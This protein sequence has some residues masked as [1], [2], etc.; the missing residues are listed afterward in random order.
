MLL[1]V[2]SEEDG[3]LGAF[4]A[5]EDDADFGACLIPEPTG[6][7]L[8]CAQAGAVTFKGVVRGK[9]AHAALRL[10][11]KSA[12]DRYVLVHAALAELE[13]R[14]NADVDHPLMT[15]HELPYPVLVGK[16][17]GGRWSSQ[18]PDELV[19]EGR[20]GVPIG[21]SLE[22]ARSEFERV[23]GDDV[24]ITWTGGQFGSGETDPAHPFAQLVSAARGRGR[25]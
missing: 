3:G 5:L 13:G 8:V 23:V 1:A 11:G 16:V 19:F 2:P 14:I 25:P 15:A 7:E 4:A 18:V 9:A 21:Q 20:L 22:A 12:I 24:A 17:S 10:E 6:F